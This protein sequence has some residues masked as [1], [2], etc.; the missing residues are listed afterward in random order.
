MKEEDLDRI[1]FLWGGGGRVKYINMDRGSSYIELPEKIKQAK[2]C[3]YVANNYNEC[4][5]YAMLAKFVNGAHVDR[6]NYNYVEL[7]HKNNFD[8]IIYLVYLSD[9]KRF[10]KQNPATYCVCPLQLTS[11]KRMNYT[12]LLLLNCDVSH[13]NY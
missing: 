2:V 7:M 5:R 1:Y 10:E 9:V 8:G 13:D 6:P 11:V 12:D 3:I 4:F